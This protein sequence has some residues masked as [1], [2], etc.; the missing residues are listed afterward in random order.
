M[1]RVTG[2]TV[3]RTLK[4]YPQFVRIDLRKNTDFIHILEEK[5][6]ELSPRK[7]NSKNPAVTGIP[8][9]GYVTIEQYFEEAENDIIEYCKTHDIL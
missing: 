2:I 4:G 8:P 6:V 1:S 3:E 9:R 5:G 7:D